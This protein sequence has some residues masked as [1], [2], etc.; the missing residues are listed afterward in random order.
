VVFIGMGATVLKVVQGR[1]SFEARQTPY[2]DSFLT[3]A[4]ILAL[5]LLVCWCGLY[6]PAPLAALLGDAVA[7]WRASHERLLPRTR[8]ADQRPG[9]RPLRNS[10]PDAGRVPP[11]ILAGVAARQRVSALFGAASPLA[12][13]TRLY[14]VLAD[15]EQNLLSAAAADVT[16]ADIRR[17]PRAAPRCTSSSARSPSSSACAVRPPVAQA[18]PLLPLLDRRDAW[19]RDAAEPILPAVGDFYRVE[20]DEVHEVASAR[21]CGRDRAR[22]LPLPVPR[23]TG[24][25]PRDR[26][27]LPPPRRGGG[28]DRRPNARTVHF[29]ETLSGD[30]TV[31]HTTTYCQVIEGLSGQAASARAMAIR[32]IA[33][34]LER[35]AN[36]IG[37]LGA[38]AGDVGFLPTA[39]FCGRIR[40]DFLNMTALLCGSRFG[41]A[42]V[43]PGGVGFDLDAARAAELGRRLDAG[44]KDTEVAVNLL[45]ST[46]SVMAASKTW[47]PCP[48]ARRPSSASSARRPAPPDWTATSAATS[49]PALLLL[50]HPRL[51]LETGDVFARAFMRWPRHPA[52]HRVHPQPASRSAR[53]RD[54]RG[55]QGPR[56]RRFVRGPHE[57]WRGEVCHV[58]LTTRR[59]AS[60]AT[61]SWAPFHNWTGSPTR[62]ATG[63]LRLSICNKSFKPLLLRTRP[64]IKATLAPSSRSTA[65]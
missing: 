51:H 50:A 30:S 46:Q 42:L 54:A 22:P 18:C 45:W 27:R 41:R 65:R 8:H 62:C 15:D 35:L 6:I 7:S 26:P 55:A 31:A 9:R 2:R 49:P 43:R 44:E 1:A 47:G 24:L 40:G 63:D 33:L 28:A 11:G 19:G 25:P 56:P 20:G 12:G 48:A 61:R 3:A 36:H 14:A 21:A 23:R 52:L 13:A 57:G 38:L 37:D 16:G 32:A 10:G 29:A 34:E 53:R 58:A 59:A 4:P 17:S 39:S 5:M 64:M 60:P